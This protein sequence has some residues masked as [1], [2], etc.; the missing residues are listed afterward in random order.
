MNLQEATK[1]LQ[2]CVDYLKS[3]GFFLDMRIGLKENKIGNSAVTPQK[4]TI[5]TQK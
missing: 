2:E 5:I 4:K 3:E 1:K